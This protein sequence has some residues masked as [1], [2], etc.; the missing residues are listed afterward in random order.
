MSVHP[1][2]RE[3]A[4]QDPGTGTATEAVTPPEYLHCRDLEQALSRSDA[5]LRRLNS[6]DMSSE[7]TYWRER[8]KP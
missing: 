2:A 6:R 1:T 7:A 3:T 8:N 5:R 4:A